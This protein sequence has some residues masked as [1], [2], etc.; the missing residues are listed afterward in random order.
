MNKQENSEYT[1][2]YRASSDTSMVHIHRRFHETLYQM[3]HREGLDTSAI[4]VF[5]GHITNVFNNI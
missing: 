2:I 4:F 5:E 1:V 3:L